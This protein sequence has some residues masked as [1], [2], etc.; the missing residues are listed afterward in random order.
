MECCYYELNTVPDFS[1]YKYASLSETGPSGVLVQHQ[2]FWRQLNQWG[3]LFGGSIHFIYEFNPDRPAGQRMKLALRFDAPDEDAA[4]CVRQV[5]KASVLAPY[6]DRLALSKGDGMTGYQYPWQVNLFKKERFIASSF[7]EQEQF[8]TCS[9]W[10]MNRDARLYAMLRLM[11]ETGSHCAY[12]V[13]IYPVDYCD[14]AE[15]SLAYIL[16][17]LRELNSFKVKTGSGSVSSGGRDENAKKAL[18]FYEGML[19][20]ITTSPHFLMNIQVLGETEALAK[21]ILDAAASE[22][23][24]AG[25]HTVYGERFGRDIP[26][27]TT[28]GFTCWSDPSAPE[29]LAFLPH[30]MTLEQMVPFAVLPV[31]FPGEAI[32]MPKETVPPRQEGMLIGYDDR[33]HEIYF[34]WKKLSK[35][36]FMAGMPGS[37]KTNTMMYL[38]SEMY[39]AGIPILIMEPAKKE[40]RVLTTLEGMKEISLFSPSANSMFP[41]HINPFEFPR[42]MKL[43]DHINRLLDVFNGTF[44]LDPPMPM[45]LT[46]GIQACYEELLWLPGMVNQGNLPYPTMRMLYAQIE[47]LLDK[48]QYADEVKSNLKS[49]LQVRIGSLLAREMGDIFDVEASTFAPESWLKKSAV[50]ELASLGTGPSNFLMLMLMTLIRETLDT[51]VYDPEAWGAKPRHVIFLEEAH[52]LIANTSVQAAGGLDPKI[53]ATAFITKMLAEVRA[54]G[55]GIVIAD[56]LPTAMAPEVIKNTSLKFGL[57]L[58]SEDERQLLGAAMSADGVQMERM[59]IF[60]PG[61]SLVSYEDLLRP[62]EIRIPEFKG[63]EFVDDEK[64]LDSALCNPVYHDNMLKSAEIMRDKF[65]KRKAEQIAKQNQF[66]EK[67][68]G[69]YRYWK[70]H[71]EEVSEQNRGMLREKRE[72][73][74]EYEELMEKW[75][76]LTL[77]IL[78]YMGVTMIRRERLAHMTECSDQEKKA[79]VNAHNQWL[80]MIAG[81]Y[82][83][84]Q[85]ERSLF[86]EYAGK[87]GMK[88]LEEAEARLIRQ[89]KLIR[90]GWTALQ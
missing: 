42:G 54:L 61:Q 80:D 87:A 78:I 67:V 71:P 40:Y 41:L 25:N 19:D 86:K 62:F 10:E 33:N 81:L 3:K 14:A 50:I 36:G 82:K 59:G 84:V 83:S 15:N 63:D 7:N 24:A 37:G 72:F 9:E 18:D 48:Y 5:M 60:S 45:L 68:Q 32:E 16:P 44:Q 21:Q 74:R 12:C 51:Q 28:G 13:D 75:C 90:A 53:S 69:T 56:Q 52:N 20:D 35:H 46:E 8:Y 27:A 49:I 39:R 4:E 89:Q 47:K 58:T 6:Y 85:F 70:A 88:P 64:L 77:D 11:E 17:H 73:Q 57:R 30:L 26:A 34:P 79:A 76:R 43:A 66:F 55:E 38:A 65:E 29:G 1:L 23:L 2:A 31:L 22:A